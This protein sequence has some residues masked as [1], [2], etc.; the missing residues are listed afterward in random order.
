MSVARGLP[1]ELS[2]FLKYRRK[3]GFSP[4][5]QKNRNYLAFL[6]A[7]RVP[8][9]LNKNFIRQDLLSPRA[10]RTSL[11][12]FHAFIRLHLPL[13]FYLKAAL[14]HNVAQRAPVVASSRPNTRSQTRSQQPAPSFDESFSSFTTSSDTSSE[15][16]AYNQIMPS[17]NS[18][19]LAVVKQEGNKCP[20]FHFGE[21]TAEISRQFDTACHNFVTN[22]DI[23]DDKQTIKVMTAL[24]G[25]QWESWVAVHRDELKA[26]LLDD[27]LKRFKDEF[28]P[29]TWEVDV[30]IELNTMAQGDNQT[31]RDFA[32]AVQ[33]TNSLLLGTTSHLDVAHLR[34]RI[35][36]GVDKILNKRARAMDKNIHNIAGLPQWIEALK[37]LD[38]Q[39]QDERAERRAELEALT[40]KLHTKSR[41]N[42]SLAD[43]S[44]KSNTAS[45][46]SSS[47][48]QTRKDYPPK[49]TRDEAELLVTNSGCT[50]CRKPFVFHMKFDNL[51]KEKC[52]FPK[53]TN[54]K[55]V[56]QAVVDSARRAHES[57]K[58]KKAV[59]AVTP[60]SSSTNASA[61]PS[62]H[63]VAAVMGYATNPAGYNGKYPSA[64][65]AS[66]D[67]DEDQ[68]D[69]D[70]VCRAIAAFVEPL[71]E[72]TTVPPMPLK[73]DLE[74]SAPLT[75]PHLFWRASASAPDS[76]PIT[77]DCL[78]DPGSHLVIIRENLV[79]ELSLKR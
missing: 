8:L 42:C 59:A 24:K 72:D 40:Q 44:C 19:N 41:D 51:P 31:F 74:N 70:D 52:D 21:L 62:S 20:I 26:L 60:A 53:G 4:R 38:T 66:D 18:K 32:N 73:A 77:F 65:F 14:S 45:T 34:T 79:N 78:I 35:E 10:F 29:S 1:R 13:A 12:P 27:F 36:A 16:T 47:N 71:H 55:P 49:L 6:R 43:P 39:L 17:S 15:F 57:S 22:K 56:T 37:E 46:T 28:M 48:T 3:Q 25:F 7:R 54:Y 23:P 64:V 5:T 68:L 61:G 76:F 58:S 33:N 30:C 11:H 9:G 75:V 67:S 63:P 2:L 50:R 69:S